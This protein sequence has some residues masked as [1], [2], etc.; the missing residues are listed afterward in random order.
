MACYPRTA[1]SAERQFL[2]AVRLE[3]NDPD[4]HYQFGLYYKAMRVRSRAISEFRTTV[5]LN[6]RHKQARAELEAL[7]PK[8]TAL[9]SLKKLFR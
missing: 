9:I 6:P 1:K 4:I 3:P 2:E 5:S 8:D 7:S